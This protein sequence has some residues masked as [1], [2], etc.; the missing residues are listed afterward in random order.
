MT[1]RG[2]LTHEINDLAIKHIGR[3]LTLTELRFIPY[4][5]HVMVNDQYIEPEKI[6][7]AE[8]KILSRW[9]E[10]GLVLRKST[11]TKSVRMRTYIMITKEFWDFI[12]EALWL[13]YV[14]YY[15]GED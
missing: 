7:G 10:E 2:E 8:R 6:N 13:G 4:I 5:Q 1:K 3:E 14:S 9:M 11:T 12:C 15:D